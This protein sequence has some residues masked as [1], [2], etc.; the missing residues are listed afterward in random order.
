MGSTKVEIIVPNLLKKYYIDLYV[1]QQLKQCP[2]LEICVYL[3][4]CYFKKCLFYNKRMISVI[5]I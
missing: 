5:L 3:I 4:Y 2:S 1:H